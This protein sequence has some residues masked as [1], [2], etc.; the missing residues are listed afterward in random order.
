MQFAL[1]I[2]ESPEA[3]ATR[4]SDETDA[5]L[6]AWRAYHKALV[7]A[8]IFAG[9]DPLEA[10]ETGTTVRL[11]EG[12]KSRL[13][14]R[15]NYRCRRVDL[16]SSSSRPGLLGSWLILVGPQF[17]HDLPGD[18][19]RDLLAQIERAGFGHYLHSLACGIVDHLTDAAM[20]EMV[21]ELLAD[22]CRTLTPQEV[23]EVSHEF[24]A[25]DH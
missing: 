7:E 6:G 1:L 16:L 8:G 15:V 18:R 5:Y 14:N 13:D 12:K 20:R 21:F 23:P 2:Y 19:V 3:F 4:N 25:G 11:E 22:F 10:P 17:R 24:F 9:G